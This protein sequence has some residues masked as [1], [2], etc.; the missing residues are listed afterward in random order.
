MADDDDVPQGVIVC[1]RLRPMFVKRPD[2]TPGREAT[3]QRVVEM[4]GKAETGVGCAVTKIWNPEDMSAEPRSY[5]FDRSWWSCDGSMEDPERP[6]F[7]IPDGPNSKYVD[8]DMVWQD[9]GGIVMKNAL[10]GYNCTVF[11]YGQSGCGKSY[12]VVGDSPNLGIIPR[13][14]KALFDVVDGNTDPDVRYHVEIAMVEVYMDEVYDL[15]EPR[16]KERQKLNVFNNKGEAAMSGSLRGY[17][18]DV[19]KMNSFV[20]IFPFKGYADFWKIGQMKVV[21]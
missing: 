9:V 20:D 15:L 4:E 12:S 6:G 5:A 2:G 1:V 7:R 18:E 16:K 19:L 21:W 3:C 17:V 11:A 10:K 8:Q 14:V 13:T